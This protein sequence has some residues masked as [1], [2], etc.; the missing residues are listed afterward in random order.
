MELQEPL[1]G[2]LVFVQEKPKFVEIYIYE[3]IIAANL[4]PSV[5][6]VISLHGGITAPQLATGL[7]ACIQ[8]TP[9]FVETKMILDAKVVNLIP[10]EDEAIVVQKYVTGPFV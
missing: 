5:E 3:F 2:A 9:E 1:A 10:S 4:V 6:Q 7:L 8:L